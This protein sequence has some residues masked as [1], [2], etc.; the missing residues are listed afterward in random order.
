MNKD[1]LLKNLKLLSNLEAGGNPARSWREKNRAIFLMQ[2][3]NSRQNLPVKQERTIKEQTFVYARM[4][5]TSTWMRQNVFRP[6]LI[7]LSSFAVIFSGWIASV[8][9]SINSVPGDILYPLK[10]ATEAAQFTLTTGTENKTNL[11]VEFADRR[12]DEVSKITESSDAAK[13]N[14]DVQYAVAEFKNNINNVK[15]NLEV[16]KASASTETVVALAK[17]VDRKTDEYSTQLDRAALTSSESVQ[18]NLE[19]A[20]KAVEETGVKAVE[21][22]VSHTTSITSAEELKQKL[23]EKISQLEGRVAALA[24]KPVA[25]ST[26]TALESADAKKSLNAARTLIIANNLLGALQ[27]VKNATKIILGESAVPV[28]TSSISVPVSETSTPATTN[29]TTIVKP[30][31]T[32]TTSSSNNEVQIQFI[33]DTTSLDW[34]EAQIM[35]QDFKPTDKP[36]EQ[37][38]ITTI[39][40]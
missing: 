35:S 27:E 31:V 37:E 25:S 38:D 29:T 24:L 7:A 8:S 13:K 39:T 19:S 12:L 26:I 32:N 34:L 15:D 23:E 16:L 40:K 21:V 9:A 3:Q 17:M 20:K 5:F 4:F 11:Q 10:R 18:E 14:A 2:V 30:A 36:L 6:S 1:K 22:M 28:T 33:P